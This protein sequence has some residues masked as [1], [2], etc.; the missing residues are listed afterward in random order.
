MPDRVSNREDRQAYLS[1]QA[2][3]KELRSAIS[4]LSARCAVETEK[5][6]GAGVKLAHVEALAINR[7][8]EEMREAARREE[9]N[10][11]RQLDKRVV[12]YVR[13]IR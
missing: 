11:Y 5:R 12:S 6:F 4:A 9:E 10:N 1:L 8:L 13:C 2:S 7:T 3:C